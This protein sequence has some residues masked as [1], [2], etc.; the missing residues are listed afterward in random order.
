MRE[1]EIFKFLRIERIILVA[2]LILSTTGFVLAAYLT[3]NSPQHL[4]DEES[5]VLGN[6]KVALNVYNVEDLYSWQTV[7][8][9]D[10]RELRVLRVLPGGFVGSEC[11]PLD[12]GEFHFDS[13]FVYSTD[14]F[15]GVLIIYGS[16]IGNV[17]GRS[18]NGTLAYI[19]FEYIKEIYQDPCIAQ[20][21]FFETFL[22]NSNFSDIPFIIL[23]D[24]GPCLSS[25][26]ITTL[27]L[28]KIS[29]E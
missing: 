8:L 9:F 29:E 4:E 15:E 27:T 16:L 26:N 25:N 20:E 21:R 17:S 6:F 10:P 22:K 24:S 19:V 3:S 13:I 14:S 18:G 28:T 7:I 12:D 5:K 11:I 1:I 23:T 2:I